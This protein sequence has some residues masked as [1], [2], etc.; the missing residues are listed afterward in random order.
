MNILRV[1]CFQFCIRLQ[2]D[3]M[4]AHDLIRF[5]N[6]PLLLRRCRWPF[7]CVIMHILDIIAIIVRW[8]P[9]RGCHVSVRFSS[10]P[11]SRN[12]PNFS[13]Y[14]EIWWE[15]CACFGF[16]Q[17]RTLLRSLDPYRW[18]GVMQTLH[19]LLQPPE[20]LSGVMCITTCKRWKIILQRSKENVWEM[21]SCKRYMKILKKVC[22]YTIWQ[23][24]QHCLS[25]C[26][27][28]VGHATQATAAVVHVQRLSN[29]DHADGESRGHD[30]GNGLCT[31]KSSFMSLSL[32]EKYLVRLLRP[33]S[34]L[35]Q[36]HSSHLLHR[37]SHR[38]SP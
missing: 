34:H 12:C 6:L 11:L 23:T 25:W 38:I 3:V 21:C 19:R 37:W 2:T 16:F 35:V 17:I 14:L 18:D 36:L 13:H 32:I 15:P 1:W 8:V 31:G 30:K 7:G 9:L 33:Q 28:P 10:I 26:A 27:D 4:T 22:L 24:W 29:Q 5:H 20:P